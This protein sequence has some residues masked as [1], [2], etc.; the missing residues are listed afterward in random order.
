MKELASVDR[1]ILMWRQTRFGARDFELRSG[2]DL[3]ATMY[4]PKW[5]SE[6]AVAE[7]AENKWC[8]DRLGLF[9]RRVVITE[10]D[11][12]VE[13]ASFEPDWRG[14]GELYSTHG[15][16]YH[17]YRTKAFRNFWALA[18]GGENVILEVQAG[19]RRFKY[20]ADVVLP[21]RSE[22]LPGLSLLIVTT[23]Y[24]GYMQIQDAA[25]AAATIAATT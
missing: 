15:E 6:C 5:L 7:D 25:A 22:A 20:E 18:D 4:W 9:R 2:D 17:W 10:A 23:W 19:T 3:V 11:S 24:L 8:L 1:R 16:I 12:G 13:V 21:V 14:D